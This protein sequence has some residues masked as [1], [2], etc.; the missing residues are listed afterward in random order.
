[1]NPVGI[2][3]LLL[4]LCSSAAIGYLMVDPSGVMKLF[5]QEQKSKAAQ[6]SSTSED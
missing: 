5:K 6:A 1:M 3:S 4:L 2:I